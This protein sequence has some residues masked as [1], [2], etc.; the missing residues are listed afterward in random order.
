MIRSM[1]ENTQHR[2]ATHP[3]RGAQMEFDQIHIQLKL[4]QELLLKEQQMVIKHQI[5]KRE[6]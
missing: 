2:S 3:T 5:K 4:D 6:P 1:S